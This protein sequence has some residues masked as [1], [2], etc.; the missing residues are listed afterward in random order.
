[1]SKDKTM[2]LSANGKYKLVERLPLTNSQKWCLGEMAHLK[3]PGWWTVEFL[4]KV[5]TS[6]DEHAMKEAIGYVIRKFECLRT[7]MVNLDGE[8]IQE[9]YPFPEANPFDAHDLSGLDARFQQEEIKRVCM[10]ERDWLLPARGNM[11]RLLHFKLSPNEGRLWFCMHHVISDFMS[12][13]ILA[14]EFMSAYNTIVQGK[15]I[16]HQVSKEYRKWLY[17]VDGYCR[18]V[19][20]PSELDYW[21]S[22][23][24]HKSK[25]LPSDY[26]D[27]FYN[28]QQVIDAMAKNVMIKSFRKDLFWI[29]KDITRELYSKVG[30]DVESFLIAVFFLAVV[31]NRNME[32]LDISVCNSGRNVLPSEYGINIYELP[33]YLALIRV[34]L[35]RRP[36]TGGVLS[37]MENIIG[38]IQ[39]IPSGGAGFSLI[40]EY[41]KND[42]LRNSFS[43]LRRNWYV[44]F[45]YLGRLDSNFGND[46]Y[47]MVEEDTGQQAHGGEIQKYLLECFA[48]VKE[49]KLFFQLTY[50]EEYFTAGTMEN[51][52]KEI[53]STLG[54]IVAKQPSEKFVEA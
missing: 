54:A 46:Q 37:D 31:N 35:L 38:Q 32:W 13:V 17:L 29:D 47:E 48:G 42:E 6:M 50:S 2:K 52:A 10:K 43:E 51:I 34:V 9:V 24:W 44:F 1:M 5:H 4:V 53:R 3:R 28:E 25:L 21:V 15:E 27:R 16:K 19:L 14:N 23:P 11:V 45:N 8:W 41:I 49:N 18:D 36:G 12:A 40:K 39:Q 7:K 33:G 22:F 30:T 26:S 20:L